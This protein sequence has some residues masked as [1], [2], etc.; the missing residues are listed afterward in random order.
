MVNPD[1]STSDETA[2]AD[3]MIPR[4]CNSATSRGFHRQN[5]QSEKSSV[6]EWA[7]CAIRQILVGIF[8]E[9]AF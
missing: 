1:G 2:N 8:Q 4:A 3:S 9:V 6:S 5:G 7:N